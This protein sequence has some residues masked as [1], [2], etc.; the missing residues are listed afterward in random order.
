MRG[1]CVKKVSNEKK[2]GQRVAS[3]RHRRGRADAPRRPRGRKRR[4]ILRYVPSDKGGDLHGK[5]W[6]IVPGP[7][8]SDTRR[9]PSPE[10]APTHL[11][12][13]WGLDPSQADGT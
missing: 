12:R 3:D 1:D 4:G 5:R 13:T 7:G 9:P 11:P 8:P 2:R 10:L 6:K